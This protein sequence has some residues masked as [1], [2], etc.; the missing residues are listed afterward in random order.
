MPTD[1]KFARL[2]T[3]SGRLRWVD[4]TV[5]LL[6]RATGRALIGTIVGSIPGFIL[7]FAIAMHFRIGGLTDV[8]VF[9]LSVAV[10]AAGVFA[11]VLQANVLPVLQRMKAFGRTAFHKRLNAIAGFSTVAVLI[12]YTLIAVTAVV[13]TLRRSSWTSQQHELM[14]MTTAILGLFVLASS[15]NSVISAGL[16][17]LDR[18]LAPAATQVVKSLAPLIALPFLPRNASGLLWIACLVALGEPRR[19]AFCVHNS[20]AP[21]PSCPMWPLH[22]ASRRNYLSGESRP[23]TARVV[24]HR[25]R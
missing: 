22:P 20:S 9:S 4:S 14:W 2:R 12:L 6:H 21:C 19:Q 18:F 5:A 17:A 3:R 8:Y 25:G 13:Y 16:N 24:V 11:G 7:P 10:F 23:P 1:T 15:I